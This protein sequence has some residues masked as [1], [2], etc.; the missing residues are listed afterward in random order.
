MPSRTKTNPNYS[1][2]SAEEAENVILKFLSSDGSDETL[3]DRSLAGLYFLEQDRSIVGTKTHKMRMA[4][5]A[6]R[7]D[8][9]TAKIPD[10][11]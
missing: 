2:N 10:R 3:Y 9:I 7:K 4:L 5:V 11:S 1:P 6:W 8:K